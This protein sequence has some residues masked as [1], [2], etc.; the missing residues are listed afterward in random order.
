MGQNTLKSILPKDCD[1]SGRKVTILPRNGNPIKVK[2]SSVDATNG[3]VLA[4]ALDGAS[5]GIK[6]FAPSTAAKPGW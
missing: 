5:T 3:N 6:S 2:I 4:E 1:I